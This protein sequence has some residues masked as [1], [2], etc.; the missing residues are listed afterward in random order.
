[1]DSFCNLFADFL[2]WCWISISFYRSRKPFVVGDN[3]F[4]YLPNWQKSFTMHLIE[5]ATSCSH[6]QGW[7]SYLGLETES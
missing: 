6:T 1:M 7:P 3:K 5:F 2:H 4:P